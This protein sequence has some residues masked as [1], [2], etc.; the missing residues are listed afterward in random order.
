MADTIKLWDDPMD[1]KQHAPVSQR[2]EPYQYAPL[3]FNDPEAIR[4]VRV[5]KGLHENL[6]DCEL[7]HT[8]VDSEYSALSYVWGSADHQ[9]LIFL[10][11]C[12]CIVRKNLWGFLNVAR[13]HSSETTLWIDALCIAQ[14][15]LQEKN[16][17]VQMMSIIFSKAQE[18][19]V[20][21]G[22]DTS[23]VGY[24]FDIIADSRSMNDTALIKACVQDER[25]WQGFEQLHHAEY[26]NRAWI[27]QEFVLPR[28]GLLVQGHLQVSFETFQQFVQR[29]DSF[30][31]R[32]EHRL[33]DFYSVID[34]QG[35]DLWLL[36]QKVAKSKN[37]TYDF[38]NWGNVHISPRA[39]DD[40]RDRV[41]VMLVFL[42]N[43]KDL[44]VDY[45]LSPFDLFLETFCLAQPPQIVDLMA[46]LLQL[47]PVSIMMY[48]DPSLIDIK[49]P[50]GDD[51]VRFPNDAAKL[52]LASAASEDDR[53]AWLSVALCTSKAER[54][55][56]F[57]WEQIEYF[58]DIEVFSI[59]A[60]NGLRFPGDA[61]RTTALKWINSNT[62]LLLN[63]ILPKP[64]TSLTSSASYTRV[65]DKVEF[66]LNGQEFLSQKSECCR[67]LGK[68][69]TTC[70]PAPRDVYYMLLENPRIK[71]RHL[72]AGAEVNF[73]GPQLIPRNVPYGG[74][75]T[76]SQNQ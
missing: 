6:I 9:Q 45:R 14:Q 22:N 2:Y 1:A 60:A 58:D 36:R 67:L 31:K 51:I 8:T 52:H 16:H 35:R 21:L 68:Y 38:N 27:L 61:G 40:I 59:A 11:G 30:S 41:Y 62:Y 13:K 69:K 15:N 37:S 25:F 12:L 71:R 33:Q 4:V 53:N 32:L 63:D 76:L 74:M 72:F 48:S 50:G 28:K 64:S 47:T 10:N 39:C 44:Q 17:Q 55:E 65:A 73:G 3:D 20:W 29:V 49:D 19:R 5:K 70:T 34:S 66:G 43:G 57:H 46:G 23:D 42:R 18:V 75:I 7:Q 26:W 24:A 54:P 56:L